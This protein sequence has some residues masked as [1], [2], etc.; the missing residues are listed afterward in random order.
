MRQI[1][2][3][4]FYNTSDSEQFTYVHH[5]YFSHGFP[6]YIHVQLQATISS[7]TR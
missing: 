6:P 5:M 2:N 4:L 3:Q 1:L 7:S